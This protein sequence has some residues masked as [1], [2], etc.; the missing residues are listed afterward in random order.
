[1]FQIL[2]Y[3]KRLIEHCIVTAVKL[4]A[5]TIESDFAAGYET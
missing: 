4:I 1:M 2:I 5:P 3:R